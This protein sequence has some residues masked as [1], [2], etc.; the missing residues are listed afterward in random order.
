MS[1][2]SAYIMGVY[3]KHVFSKSI[4]N[5]FATL[6][7]YDYHILETFAKT[8][9]CRKYAI[10]LGM[11][12]RQIARKVEIL[13][14]KGFVHVTKKVQYKNIKKNTKGE[15]R[16]TRIFGLTSKGF[17]ASLRFVN[18]KHNYL[19]KSLLDNIENQ[20]LKEIILNYI[21]SDLSYFLK[22]NELR[23]IILDNIKDISSWFNEYE[24][25]FGFSKESKIILDNMKKDKE[26][27]SN[28]L[29]EKIKSL[30]DNKKLNSM[31]NYLKK[32]YSSINALSHK[33]NFKEIIKK[34]SKETIHKKQLNNSQI[35]EISDM[36]TEGIHIKT[37]AEYEKY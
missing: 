7:E 29:N 27:H 18:I 9:E 13:E 20:E 23:G 21:K 34:Y 30:Y 15:K 12:G 3:Q 1:M 31:N 22:H 36:I 26:T 6:D 24:N 17:I 16:Y 5:V 2:I 8:G 4:K 11:S 19:T 10:N 33:Q 37:Y 25:H 14:N 35:M 32:W 28:I